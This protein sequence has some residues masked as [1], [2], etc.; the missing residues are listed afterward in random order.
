MIALVRLDPRALRFWPR[1]RSSRMSAMSRPSRSPS[2]FM[3]S[4]SSSSS[5]NLTRSRR[6]VF[7]LG[8]LVVPCLRPLDILIVPA[9]S[10]LAV[11]AA[12]TAR[13]KSTV[14][15]RTSV[16]GQPARICE[17]KKATSASSRAS[18]P[19]TGGAALT[20]ASRRRSESSSSSGAAGGASASR[21]STIRSVRRRTSSG[22]SCRA[23]RSIRKS[24]AT[25]RPSADS[26]SATRMT[27]ACVRAAA[28]AASSY[29]TTSASALSP[30]AT[31]SSDARPS[32]ASWGSCLHSARSA[33]HEMAPVPLFEQRSSLSECS[34]ARTIC[35]WLSEP[36]C[37]LSSPSAWTTSATK[38]SSLSTLW[39]LSL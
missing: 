23:N 37:T 9:P 3:Y 1:P 28:T 11:A 16:R 22:M 39:V 6:L 18:G 24:I 7:F 15:A 5:T 27:S 31:C 25:A 4:T 19:I 36:P 38:R 20:A 14:T 17:S 35:T 34:M 26:R 8:A 12:S 2:T 30:S 29:A 13:Q 10:N 33:A 21:G 32:A